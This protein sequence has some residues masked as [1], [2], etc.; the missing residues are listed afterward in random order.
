MKKIAIILIFLYIFCVP[1]EA[2]HD[3]R[4]GQSIFR[5][6]LINPACRWTN[7]SLE[8]DA[9]YRFP[10]EKNQSP[11][12]GMFNFHA[13]IPGTSWGAGIR[14]DFYSGSSIRHN[15]Q[16]GM[17]L[18]FGWKLGEDAALKVG[19]GTGI[20]KEEY[21]FGDIAINGTNEDEN[22]DESNFYAELGTAF[23]YADLQIGFSTY[24]Y[25][26]YY[27]FF[28]NSRYNI[29]LGR[30]WKLGPLVSY[31][32]YKNFDGILDLNSVIGY[33]QLAEIGLG[34]STN[35]LINILFK[36][37]TSSI[38][39]LFFQCSLATGDTSDLFKKIYEFGIKLHID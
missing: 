39:D 17:T 38:L 12:G 20:N 33:G 13:M 6:E 16:V 19:A 9:V 29:D 11:R 30:K 32:A 8:L 24:A 1:T 14:G 10:W 35:D 27:M 26:D 31:S 15:N 18:D 23:R 37:R 34:Y 22:F 25:S 4:Y 5:P 21:N 3:V 28:A 36:A 2:Q 7:Q